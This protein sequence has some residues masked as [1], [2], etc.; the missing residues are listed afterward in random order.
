MVVKSKIA[1][2]LKEQIRLKKY[3]TRTE[4]AYTKCHAEWLKIIHSPSEPPIKL[5]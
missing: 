5:I 2:R 4:K 1:D 3:S